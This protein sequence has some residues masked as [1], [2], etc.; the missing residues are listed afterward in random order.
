[1]SSKKVALISVH[2]NQNRVMPVLEQAVIDK[3]LPE[4]VS[5]LHVDMPSHGDRCLISVQGDIYG[6]VTEKLKDMVIEK[7]FPE[8][9]TVVHVNTNLSAEIN[10][11]NSIDPS[12]SGFVYPHVSFDFGLSNKS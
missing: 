7:K 6:F 9:V 11:E 4:G 10:A 12:S 3:V 8:G 5:I 2:G 1:M